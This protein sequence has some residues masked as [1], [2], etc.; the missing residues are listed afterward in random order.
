M[1]RFMILSI[2]ALAL[3]PATVV[4]QAGPGTVTIA[5]VRDLPPGASVT[6]QRAPG[7]PARHLILI[8]AASTPD[9]LAAAVLVLRDIRGRHGE[10]AERHLVASIPGQPQRAMRTHAR[11]LLERYLEQARS[12]S[13]DDIE[14]VGR[15]PAIRVPLAQLGRDVQESGLR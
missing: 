5:L 3:L 8:T 2:V 12:A 11:E 13:P 9:D 7:R 4:A 1:S 14:G 10:D 6:V 15:V